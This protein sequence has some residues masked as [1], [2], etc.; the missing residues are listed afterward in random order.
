MTDTDNARAAFIEKV[1]LIAQAEGMPRSAGRLFGLLLFDGTAHAFGQ[2]AEE[3][4]ISR[5]NVSA[6]VRILEERELIV[7]ETRPGDRK[8]YFRLADD[9]FPTLLRNA[10]ARTAR[11]ATE[12]EKDLADLPRD[13]HG[14]RERIRAYAGFYRAIVAGLE[15]ALTDV[16]PPTDTTAT[17]RPQQGGR[18]DGRN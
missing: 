15:H 7:R 2:L 3:L 18:T 13:A 11:A 1:G 8:E 12:I 17:S 14:A 6:S 4:Q 5:G 16:A 9:P 10:Q